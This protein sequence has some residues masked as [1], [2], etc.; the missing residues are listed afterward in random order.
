MKRAQ[1]AALNPESPEIFHANSEKSERFHA[2][3]ESRRSFCTLLLLRHR[4]LKSGL[5]SAENRPPNCSGVAAGW[6]W[7][8]GAPQRDTGDCRELGGASLQ[9]VMRVAESR[10]AN[11]R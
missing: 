8:G 1:M 11:A 3:S 2:N 10:A 9:Q 7:R 4:S 6:G 5:H